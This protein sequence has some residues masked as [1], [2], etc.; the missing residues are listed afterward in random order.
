MSV[1][2]T[3]KSAGNGWS[4]LFSGAPDWKRHFDLTPEGT[5]LAA[6][7]Y[8]GAVVLVLLAQFLVLGRLSPPT[9][10]LSLANLLAPALALV[11]ATAAFRRFGGIAEDPATL[12]VPG[13]YLLA[14]MLLLSGALALSGIGLAGAI[15]GLT[16]F[17]LYKLAR[18]GAGLSL[19]AAFGYA[20]FNL[21]L[22]VGVPVILY[23]MLS[24][25][26]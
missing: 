26:T 16:G 9:L 21:V 3:L 23:I 19:P 14:P 13:L 4:A 6:Y 22:I 11:A 5:A 17:F 25:A 20:V 24:T 1:P 10:I 8:F 7:L 12:I 15:A 2:N 18:N